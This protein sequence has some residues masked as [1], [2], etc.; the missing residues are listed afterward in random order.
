VTL[1]PAS[2]AV[3]ALTRKALVKGERDPGDKRSNRLSLTQEGAALIMHDPLKRLGGQIA[4]LSDDQR[5][6]IVEGVRQMFAGL[7]EKD[8][9][10]DTLRFIVETQQNGL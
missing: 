3:S 9:K 10:A 1:G 8:I 4:T 5:R 2:R 6:A 7:A